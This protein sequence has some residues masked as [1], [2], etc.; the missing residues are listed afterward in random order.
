MDEAERCDELV[1]LRDGNVLA[2]EPPGELKRR[3]G[4]TSLDAAFLQL[5]AERAA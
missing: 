5:V 1:L 2:H 3:T 4:T